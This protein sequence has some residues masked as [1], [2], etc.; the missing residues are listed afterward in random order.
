MP[1][2]GHRPGGGRKPGSKSKLTKDAAIA[3]KLIGKSPAEFLDDKMNNST[4]PEV[5]MDAAKALMPYCHRKQPEERV[6]SGQIDIPAPVI[7]LINT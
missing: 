7:N 3:F 6:H 2:G 1:R 5:Q 4:D